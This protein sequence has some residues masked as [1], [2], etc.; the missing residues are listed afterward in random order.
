MFIKINNNTYNYDKFNK[1]SISTET[2]CVSGLNFVAKISMHKL[3]APD[4]ED[5]YWNIG[6]RDCN[7]IHYMY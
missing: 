3:I 4:A 1:I 7:L 5:F 2:N 6:C